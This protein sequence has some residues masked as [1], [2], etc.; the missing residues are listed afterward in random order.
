M[1]AAMQKFSRQA[2]YNPGILLGMQA[3]LLS[4]SQPGRLD[5]NQVTG[6]AGRHSRQDA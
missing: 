1:Q 5:P 2:G 4:V 3:S 6:E